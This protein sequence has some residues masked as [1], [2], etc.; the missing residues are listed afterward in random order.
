MKD[1]KRSQLTI[2]VLLII[3]AALLNSIS[4]L[5]WKFAADVDKNVILLY[6]LG[7]LASGLGMVVMMVAFRFGDVSILQPMMSLGFASSIVFG[8][9][10][11][12]E[13]VTGK[14]IIGIII[15]I[16][17]SIILGTQG[18]GEEGK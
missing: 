18:E 10:F 13:P 6:V 14:K 8:S 15:I 11:L 4:Q 17:G 16:I 3:V 7:F 12:N 2:G 5:I 1:K 9:L